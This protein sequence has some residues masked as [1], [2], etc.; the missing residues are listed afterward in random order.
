[1]A[2]LDTARP[3]I[4][5]RHPDPIF[6]LGIAAT[7]GQMAGFDVTERAPDS[8]D[9]AASLVVCD[10][11]ASR[12]LTR[13]GSV[14]VIARRPR[15]YEIEESMQRGVLGY[16]AADCALAELE[17]AVLAAAQGRR[18]LCKASAREMANSLGSEALT[19]RERDV[20]GLLARGQCNKV[21]A[22]RLG[23]AVGTVKAHVRAILA[24]L[25][26]S[27]RTQAAGIAVAR[28][29]V[30][31]AATLD[32]AAGRAAPAPRLAS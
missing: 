5:V 21:I 13:A 16:L 26:A 2:S 23:I 8:D 12:A 1:M 27:S 3:R 30:P 4:L 6:A 15:E 9:D 19:A 18:Y 20:L 29:L 7:L 10:V 31:D 22:Q 14:V 25:A 32:G 17:S 24:K 11:E 28:G